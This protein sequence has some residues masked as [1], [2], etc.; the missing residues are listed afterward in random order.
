MDTT[1][2]KPASQG[3]TCDHCSKEDC[4]SCVTDGGKSYCCQHC[5]D[6][7]KGAAHKPDE[8]AEPTVCKFC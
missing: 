2:Q 3:M 1:N 8:K 4:K 5:C 6:E 7:A